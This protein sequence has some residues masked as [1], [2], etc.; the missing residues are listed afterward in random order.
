[1]IALIKINLWCKGKEDNIR[2]LISSL[3]MVLWPTLGLKPVNLS[4]LISASKVKIA[5]MR[6][7]AKLH[8]D[9]VAVD[10]SVVQK[11]IASAVFMVLNK[12][13]EDFKSKNT[14]KS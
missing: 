14:D 4:Q 10:A 8:P 2:A 6:A 11:M 13:F 5:Y 9:K 7:V 1:M 12:A 3:D